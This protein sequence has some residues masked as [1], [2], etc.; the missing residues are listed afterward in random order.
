MRQLYIR[1]WNFSEDLT[2]LFVPTSTNPHPPVRF[3]LRG[4]YWRLNE[5]NAS[6]LSAFL[7]SHLTKIDIN[8]NFGTHP[9]ETVDPLD[10]KISAEVASEMRSAIKAL[11]SS[12]QHLNI[13]LGDGQ[14]TRLIDEISA[15][16]LGCGKSLQQ[17]RSN[18]V[19][20]TEAV[21][22]LMNLPNLHTWAT[23]QEPPEMTDLIH[24]G[25]PD[26]ATSLFPSLKALSL[27][28][29]TTLEWL[30]LF[31]AAKSCDL[32]W[33]MARNS[34]PCEPGVVR[35]A[36]NLERTSTNNMLFAVR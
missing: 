29:K 36:Q 21:V 2:R 13:H 15:F 10:R 35:R 23:E 24:H 28:G 18:L 32:R 20:S 8:T 34:L 4:L 30:C 26:G 31:K 19:L 1:E 17:F 27:R 9:H 7:S 3:A 11:P 16:I 5:D 25:V 22:H 14:E 6:F 33:T 12:V